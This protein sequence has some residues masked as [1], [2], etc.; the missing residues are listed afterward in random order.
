MD[1]WL[2]GMDFVSVREHMR[3]QNDRSPRVYLDKVSTYAALTRSEGARWGNLAAVL[4]PAFARA[5][6]SSDLEIQP[7][8][9]GD[10]LRAI[11]R[12]LAKS[13]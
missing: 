6:Q 2:A 9:A 4:E 10:Q 12:E 8:Q 7:S 5:A 13:R 3:D 11:A 1:S